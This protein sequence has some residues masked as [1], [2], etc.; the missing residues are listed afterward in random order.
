MAND[1]AVSCAKMALLIVLWTLVGWLKHRFNRIHQVTPMCPYW[2]S[3]WTH[4]EYD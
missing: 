1:S 3:H 2:R 4:G